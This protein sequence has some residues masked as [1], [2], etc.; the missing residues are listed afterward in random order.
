MFKRIQFLFTLSP[1]VIDG[2]LCVLA[3]SLGYWESSL[4]KDE[5]FKYWNPYCLYYFKECIGAFD[6]SVVAL[7]FFRSKSY[8][9]HVAKQKQQQALV[10]G[11]KQ[12][13]TK[14]TESITNEVK[15]SPDS[16]INPPT[17]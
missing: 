11:N 10:D 4:G 2:I 7:I 17:P 8:S 6:A 9:D 15:V 12:V 13:T 1:V 5:A 16:T 14:E 3:A